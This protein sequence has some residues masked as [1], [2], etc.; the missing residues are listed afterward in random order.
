[1]EPLVKAE[2][3]AE[4]LDV[5]PKYVWVEAAAGRI[6]SIK[7]GRYTRFRISEIEAHVAR[8]TRNRDVPSA[9]HGR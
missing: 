4:L 1:M 7:I 3:V 5:T 6:P 9:V 8:N 2:R